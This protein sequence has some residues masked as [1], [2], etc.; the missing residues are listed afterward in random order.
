MI[1]K[2]ITAIPKYFI[3]GLTYILNKE[4]RKEINLD[5][6][7]I[8]TTITVLSLITYLIA[9]FLLT[10]WYVQTERIKK[11]SESLKEQTTI[12][13][14]EEETISNENTTE[15]YQSTKENTNNTSSATNYSSD[16]SYL[17]I[18]FNYYTKKNEE[19]VAWIK[20]NGTNI[21][22]PV[23]KHQDNE[24]YLNHDFYKNSSNTG[25]I[26]ADYRNDFENLSN[27]TIIYGH[28]LTNRTM[29]GSLPLLLKNNWYNTET[30]RYIKISTPKYNSIWKIFSIYK[31]EPTTDYLRTKFNSTENY[32]EFLNKIKER[33]AYNF[34]VDLTYEDKIITLSTCDDTGTKRI[35]IHAKLYSL[36]NK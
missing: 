31:I 23:V 13:A 5:R 29:F 16:L 24:Y 33:S 17:N 27:N 7:L 11:F 1:I 8:P 20:V 22:Y 2:I 32:Q 15:N 18:N 3:T 25:W 6:S 4:K 28:N 14:N 26:F 36:Q 19:T 34:N 12:I 30:N 35:V 21:N 9:I 10:R